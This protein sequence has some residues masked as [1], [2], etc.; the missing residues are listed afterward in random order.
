MNRNNL[1]VDRIFTG[2]HFPS[3]SRTK[4]CIPSTN[5]GFHFKLLHLISLNKYVVPLRIDL[6]LSFALH[7]G[8]LWN[9]MFTRILVPK[10][11]KMIFLVNC[12]QGLLAFRKNIIRSLKIRMLG[13]KLSLFS[14]KL[15]TSQI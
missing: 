9:F 12:S 8:L 7:L 6:I 3:N 4:S 11:E 10:I 1:W 15:L 14:L 2:I 5:P 13:F